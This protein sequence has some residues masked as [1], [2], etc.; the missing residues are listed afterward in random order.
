MWV[1]W[2]CWKYTNV[3]YHLV[4]AEKQVLFYMTKLSL[5]M[6]LVRHLVAGIMASYLT[7]C[8]PSNHF[9]LD[10]DTILDSGK[11][12]GW[13]RSFL[14][15]EEAQTAAPSSHLDAMNDAW[16][17]RCYRIAQISVKCWLSAWPLGGSG[18]QEFNFLGPSSRLFTVLNSHL[19]LFTLFTI[20]KQ[21]QSSVEEK[22]LKKGY[23]WAVNKA[24]PFRTPLERSSTHFFPNARPHGP[25]LWT[26]QTARPATRNEPSP[27]CMISSGRAVFFHSRIHGSPSKKET[28]PRSQLLT[29]QQGRPTRKSAIIP[30]THRCQSRV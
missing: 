24:E 8:C 13:W 22:E 29:A 12:N 18:D 30:H 26:P 11:L 3:S 7:M 17:L 21:L 23:L 19:L 15:P 1:A 4:A 5:E 16:S 25:L 14:K 28:V 20:L 10:T 9:C 27:G 2:N 6:C